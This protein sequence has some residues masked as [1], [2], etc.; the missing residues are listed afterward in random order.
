MAAKNVKNSDNENEL[1]EKYE[2]LLENLHELKNQYQA[3]I[4]G[5][6]CPDWESCFDIPCLYFFLR[7][8]KKIKISKDYFL[9]YWLSHVIST[10]KNKNKIL[11]LPKEPGYYKGQP[12]LNKDMMRKWKYI[13]DL[14]F[15]IIPEKK[16]SHYKRLFYKEYGDRPEQYGIFYRYEKKI[17]LNKLYLEKNDYNFLRR[18]RSSVKRDRLKNELKPF[19]KSYKK[20]NK[21]EKCYDP[22]FNPHEFYDGF[23]KKI[24]NMSKLILKTYNYLSDGKVSKERDLQRAFTKKKSEL[25]PALDFL[26]TKEIIKWNRTKK[27]ICRLF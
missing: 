22:F 25:L 13:L 20:Y 1:K 17:D 24:I 18:W 15:K 6:I 19:F 3:L 8:A 21:N 4:D 14:F 10:V 12:L 16:H 7:R 27:T 23:D 11:L 26:E 2:I 9:L 5:K